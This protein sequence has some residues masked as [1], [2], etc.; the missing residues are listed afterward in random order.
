MS[1]P[2]EILPKFLS[3]TKPGLTNQISL[4]LLINSNW[5]I[6]RN[7][8]INLSIYFKYIWQTVY[9][10]YIDSGERE[11][12]LQTLPKL[13]K[14]LSKKLKFKFVTTVRMQQP[15]AWTPDN[16]TN[17]SET[18]TVWSKKHFFPSCVN[19]NGINI[20]FNSFSTSLN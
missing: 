10:V 2:S 8:S 3:S 1:F 17:V 4:D 16:T 15:F 13:S 12:M 18:C 14:F 11:E 19:A 6:E 5:S 7:G 20:S 9:C